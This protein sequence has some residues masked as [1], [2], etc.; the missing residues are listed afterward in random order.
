MENHPIPQDV[1]GF[2]FRLIGSMTVKQFGYLSAG[3][4]AAVI[5][6]YMPVFILLKLI[7]VPLFAAT[8]FS[9]AFVPLEGRPLD[10]MLGYYLKALLSPN[11]FVFQKG[12][13]HFSFDTVAVPAAPLPVRLPIAVQKGPRET[14]PPPNKQKQLNAYLQQLSS[15]SKTPTDKK[16]A[17]FISAIL[18]EA[19]PLPHAPVD[20]PL[21]VMTTPAPSPISLPPLEEKKD[22]VVETEEKKEEIQI[23]T[24]APPPPVQEIGSAA[25]VILK[26]DAASSVDTKVLQEIEDTLQ[27]EREELKKQEEALQAQ[28]A[29]EEK[30]QL[31]K[32][33]EAKLMTE[34]A[35]Q[36]ALENKMTHDK[37]LELERSMQEMLSQK[38]LLEQELQKMK[39]QLAKAPVQKTFTPSVAQDTPK[40][41]TQFVKQVT[42]DQTTKRGLPPSADVPNVLLGVVKDSRDNILPNILIEVKDT[43]GNPVR[44]FKTNQLGQFASATPLSNGT[45]TIEFEDTRGKNNF[46]T[47]ELVAKGEIL[48]PLEVISHDLREELRKE[49]FS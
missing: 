36:V 16:E 43:E 1:T 2:Q 32:R 23:K 5:V 24:P 42:G 20:M 6:F 19:T 40:Q 13:G 48:L 33:E 14:A 30:E 26:V 18:Q 49:L 25:P 7:F 45:Y 31:K 9:L 21:S 38:Q 41:Q 35:Q 8:G 39:D 10:A 27:K 11:Q 46:D 28:K 4:I 12:M 44:A 34:K 29:Q 17:E 22:E 15:G 3:V 37:L 47:I